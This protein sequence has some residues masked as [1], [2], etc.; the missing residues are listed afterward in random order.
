M[1]KIIYSVEEIN[2]VIN[3]LSG[4]PYGQ[5]AE[6]IKILHNGQAVREE[7]TPVKE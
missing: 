1:E 4:C 6:L 2:K 3:Y 7:V 5:V